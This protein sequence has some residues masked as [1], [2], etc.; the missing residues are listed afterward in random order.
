MPPSYSGTDLPGG[1]DLMHRGTTSCHHLQWH[2]Q[3]S[4][5]PLASGSLG[6]CCRTRVT[7]PVQEGRMCTKQGLPQLLACQ[8]PLPVVSCGPY[9]RHLLSFLFLCWLLLC[10]GGVT[11]KWSPQPLSLLPYSCFCL[12]RG[13]EGAES[14]HL[15]PFTAKLPMHTPWLNSGSVLPTEG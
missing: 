14:P 9:P 4:G 13:Q 1:Q 8:H 6:P 10:P 2:C 12:S 5:K 7:A 15:R 11:A 3:T